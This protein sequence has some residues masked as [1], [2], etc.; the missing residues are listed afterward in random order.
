MSGAGLILWNIAEQWQKTKKDTGK[1][2]E[3]FFS[4]QLFK[5]TV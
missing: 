4:L 1:N 3:H 2:S 5:L